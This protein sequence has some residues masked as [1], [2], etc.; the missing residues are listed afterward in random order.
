MR[1]A[2]ANKVVLSTRLWRSWKVNSEN[3]KAERGNGFQGQRLVTHMHSAETVDNKLG[4][5][6]ATVLQAGRS[7]VRDALW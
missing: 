5:I 4:K 7:R 3:D 1:V 2:A 6:S